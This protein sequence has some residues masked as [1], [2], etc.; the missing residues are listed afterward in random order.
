MLHVLEASEPSIVRWRPRVSYLLAELSI[1][2]RDYVQD[3]MYMATWLREINCA[4]QCKS[5]GKIKSTLYSSPRF[6]QVHAL[7]KSTLCSSPRFIQVHALFKSTL[8][9]SARFAFA[10]AVAL[11]LHLSCV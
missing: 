1:R 7:F 6:I 9:S 4:V 11:R 3:G 10:F 2:R 5:E 8:R